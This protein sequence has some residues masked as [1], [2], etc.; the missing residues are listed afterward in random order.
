MSPWLIWSA[1]ISAR[2]SANLKRSWGVSVFAELCLKTFHYSFHLYGTCC[3]WNVLCCL[4]PT[5]FLDITENHQTIMDDPFIRN[6]IDEVLKNIRTQVLIRLIQPYTR[7]EIPFVSKVIAKS[8]VT[9]KTRILGIFNWYTPPPPFFLSVTNYS[10]ATWCPSTGCGRFIGGSY[11][12]QQ[13]C[14]QNRPGEP[15]TW[16]L[17]GV[18]YP[19]LF[20]I[21]HSDWYTVANNIFMIS[22]NSYSQ[23]YWCPAI[24]R[25][26]QMVDECIKSL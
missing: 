3:V 11:F 25:N 20:S 12:R 22:P 23:V 14:W 6:Y 24:H 19:Y 15:A 17:Q 8:L 21:F 13:G 16:A 5:N 18:R 7:I 2:R 26:G 9:F 10:S 4:L 1:L